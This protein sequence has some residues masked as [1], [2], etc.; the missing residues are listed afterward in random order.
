MTGSGYDHYHDDDDDTPSFD[1]RSSS[2]GDLNFLRRPDT[3]PRSPTGS[4][5][6]FTSSMHTAPFREDGGRLYNAAQDDYSLPADMQEI[7]RLNIQHV[8][9]RKRVGQNY[10][11]PVDE[12]LQGQPGKKVLDIGCGTGLW[13]IEVGRAFPQAEF[14]GIDLVPIQPNDDEVPENVSFVQDD[15][16]KG[17]PYPDESIDIVHARLLVAG[18]RDFPALVR[19]IARVLK[20]GG[21]YMFIEGGFLDAGDRRDLDQ[22]KA[23]MARQQNT[24]ENLWRLAPGVAAWVELTSKAFTKRGLD[25]QAGF[26][27]PETV[28]KNGSFGKIHTTLVDLPMSP[29]ST[30]PTMRQVGKLMYA[31]GSQMPEASKLLVIDGLNMNPNEYAEYSARFMADL[32]DLRKKIV[33]MFPAHFTIKGAC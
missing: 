9:Y 23:D 31:D 11:G 30:E 12:H 32:N 15:V 5:F 18:I 21:L 25:P 6:T 2:Y 13:A 19:E 7:N 29:W 27:V 14:I 17:L 3:P 22:I 28:R 26:N 8:A 16:T 20:P 33:I 10:I 1:P 4:S 24:S